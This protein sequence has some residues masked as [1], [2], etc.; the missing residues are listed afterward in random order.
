MMDGVVKLGGGQAAEN[1]G[2]RERGKEHEA[3][4]GSRCMI[5]IN[6]TPASRLFQVLGLLTSGRG[7]ISFE[8][9]VSGV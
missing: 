7:I 6:I 4:K 3:R 8:R 5:F 1:F 9:G 2:L